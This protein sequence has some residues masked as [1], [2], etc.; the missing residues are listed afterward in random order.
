MSRQDVEELTRDT[1]KARRV[2][3]S[4]IAS[5][6][7]VESSEVTV[8]KVY[9]NGQ[10]K[11]RRLQ[12]ATSTSVDVEFQIMSSKPPATDLKASELGAA[13]E[14]EAKAEGITVI[15]Q[16]IVSSVEIVS[17]TSGRAKIDD[18]SCAMAMRRSWQILLVLW[19][20]R[21]W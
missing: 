15:V 7:G 1:S 18:S 21:L 13:I 8:T 20:R 14:S 4:A 16:S 17:S 6:A 11:V 19:M 3:G 9:V 5:A 10:G 2:L 12:S